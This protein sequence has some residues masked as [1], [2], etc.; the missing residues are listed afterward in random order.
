[1]CFLLE[2]TGLIVVIY[3]INPR[4]KEVET[5]TKQQKEDKAKISDMESN[6][7]KILVSYV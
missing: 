4:I 6:F 2:L 3:K 1:M 7:K 5:L